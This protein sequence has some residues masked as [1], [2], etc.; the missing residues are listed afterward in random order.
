M[1]RKA[2][3]G[4]VFEI[5]TPRGHGYI[6]Y[7]HDAPS[8]GQLIRV[9]PGLYQQRPDVKKL[10]CEGELYFVFYPLNY[11]LRDGSVKLVF[12]EALPASIV[13]FPTM[14]KRAGEDRNGKPTSWLIGDGSKQSTFGEFAHL[15][16]VRDEDLTTEQRKLSIGSTLWPHP[17]LV[18]ELTRG[19]V[20]E[21]EEE[22]RLM[23]IAEGA[24]KRNEVM[25]TNQGKPRVLDHYLYF[26]EKSNAER[27]A[28]KLR[29]KGWDVE[30]RMGPGGENWLALAKQ[31]APIAEPIEEV[32]YELEE[33]ADEL[34]GQYDGWGAA[35]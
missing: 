14:R 34:G 16:R 13:P 31:P 11:A 5:E 35:F 27:A 10:V 23:D 6:Q 3:I 19:W 18:K 9:L 25:H 22:F 15:L 7:T 24:R 4:D 21:R 17:V 28:V 20:P 32:R 33:L 2:K 12:Q 29:E 26:P 1:L 30:V 8:L